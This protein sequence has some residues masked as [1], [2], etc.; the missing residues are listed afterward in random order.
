MPQFLQRDD[1]VL[2]I[3]CIRIVVI[4]EN[5]PTDIQAS[6]RISLSLTSVNLSSLLKD[7]TDLGMV[8]KLG[9]EGDKIGS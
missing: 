1:S 7:T 3:L 2:A 4:I 5:Q 8:T 9:P 6:L